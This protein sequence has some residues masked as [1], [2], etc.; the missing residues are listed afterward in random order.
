M[1]KIH[2]E[3]DEVSLKKR[4]IEEQLVSIERELFSSPFF[5]DHKG[6][7]INLI[8]CDSQKIQELNKNYR[9]KDSETDVLSFSELDFE[10]LDEFLEE[11][12]SLGEI[13]INY[14]W[15]KEG[16]DHG[17]I[18]IR[19]LFVHGALHLIGFDHE[20]D[21]GEMKQAEKTFCSR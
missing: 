4:E 8:F 11:K 15:I 12:K 5:V 9:G 19:E 18:G 7:T 1:L 3:I 20:K 17:L 16:K 14:D 2:W 13:F 10:N 21:N 6:K